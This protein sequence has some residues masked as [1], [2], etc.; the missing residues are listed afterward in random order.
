MERTALLTETSLVTA[1]DLELPAAPGRAGTA[2]RTPARMP[3][4]RRA[5][6]TSTGAG[7]SPGGS[8][9]NGLEHRSGRRPAEDSPQHAPLSD[10]EAGTQAERVTAPN[11]RRSRSPRL[12]TRS[13]GPRP[14]PVREACGPGNGA[15][16][17]S[18]EPPLCL[19]RTTLAPHVAVALQVLVEKTESFGGRIDQNAARWGSSRPSGSTRSRTPLGGPRTQRWRYGRPREQPRLTNVERVGVRIAIHASRGL[20]GQTGETRV[21]DLETAC[22]AY[23][24]LESLVTAA[25]PDTILVSPDAARPLERRF[26]LARRPRPATGRTGLSARRARA[27]R[28]GAARRHDDLRRARVRDGARAPRPGPGRGGPRPGRGHRGRAGRR[29]VTARVGGHAS[30]SVA[31][32]GSSCGRVRSRMARR[33]RISP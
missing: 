9:R 10:E 32:A 33:R 26:A 16:W 14:G 27:A 6:A 20:V 23:A 13:A 21:I 2:S 12:G 24:V 5:E 8:A 3:P 1:D 7:G 28:P 22:R 15:N 4:G 18:C 19:H 11:R 31:K 25:E 30:P 29:E 17:R